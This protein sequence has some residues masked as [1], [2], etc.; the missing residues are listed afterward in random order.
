MSTDAKNCVLFNHLPLKDNS[1]AA[2]HDAFNKWIYW[3]RKWPLWSV[4]SLLGAWG[5]CVGVLCGFSPYRGT[6]GQPT[7]WG[8]CLY[9]SHDMQLESVS[10]TASK[11]ET[12]EQEDNKEAGG[13]QRLWESVETG[14]RVCEVRESEKMARDVKSVCRCD[15][16]GVQNRLTPTHTFLCIIWK[17]KEW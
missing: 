2:S 12:I 9:P 15:H 5:R 4:E 3:R 6:K 14:R 10:K 13:G 16:A 17:S 8:S 11:A 7:Y 1:V